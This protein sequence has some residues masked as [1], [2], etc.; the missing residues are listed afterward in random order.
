MKAGSG[1]EWSGLEGDSSINGGMSATFYLF[2]LLFLDREHVSLF[3]L[4]ISVDISSFVFFVVVEISSRNF[5]AHLYSFLSLSF[6]PSSSSF[7][8]PSVLSD[9]SGDGPVKASPIIVFEQHCSLAL[10]SLETIL[11]SIC[12]LYH[13]NT[14][15][16]CLFSSDRKFITFIF[17]HDSQSCRANYKSLLLETSQDIFPDD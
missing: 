3:T 12:S 14:G 4:F 9:Y 7:F 10:C 16:L 1:R 8:H 13:T 17:T 15:Q 6:S 2:C 5:F 11:F